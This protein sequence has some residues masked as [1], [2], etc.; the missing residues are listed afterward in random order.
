MVLQLIVDDGKVRALGRDSVVRLVDAGEPHLGPVGPRG[1]LHDRG[2]GPL[3]R[4]AAMVAHPVEAHHIGARR[5]GLLGADP[6][7]LGQLLIAGAIVV[8]RTHRRPHGR[9]E[10]QFAVPGGD[11]GGRQQPVRQR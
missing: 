3:R 9:A 8:G 7:P 6:N 2:D 4:S 11:F 1:A 10:R 5:R